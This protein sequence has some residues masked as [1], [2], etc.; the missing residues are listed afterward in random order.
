MEEIPYKHYNI[1]TQNIQNVKES[2]IFSFS[3]F[4]RAGEAG[5]Q[6][7]DL[8]FHR[9]WVRETRYKVGSHYHQIWSPVFYIIR[10]Q[11]YKTMTRREFY[12]VTSGQ[13]CIP[14]ITTFVICP[15]G[16]TCPHFSKGSNRSRRS[17]SPLIFHVKK[18]LKAEVRE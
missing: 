15:K 6:G 8:K 13:S 10:R 12:I 7:G 1:R 16:S 18:V 2:D 14:E 4:E 3:D 17:Q 5:I 9:H 11:K